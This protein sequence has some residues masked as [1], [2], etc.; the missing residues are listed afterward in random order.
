MA[1]FVYTNG[2]AI[3]D[4]AVDPNDDTAFATASGQGIG[5]WQ[6]A[7]NS[8]IVR[9]S[10]SIASCDGPTSL[11]YLFC[12]GQMRERSDILYGSQQG[13]IGIVCSCQCRRQTAVSPGI[14]ITSLK[15][16]FVDE[17]LLI[18]VQPNAQRIFVYDSALQ[19]LADI[20]T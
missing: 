16:I 14:P 7:H 4:L 20:D 3:S 5:F 19:K 12:H 18:F 8:I 15:A 2:R 11:L 9:A 6:V 13:N 10:V 17:R 1:G